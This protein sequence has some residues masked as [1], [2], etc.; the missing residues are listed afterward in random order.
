MK[1]LLTLSQEE[2]RNISERTKWGN[3][4]SAKANKIRNNSLYGYEFD[5]ENNSLIAIK[6]EAD[7]VRLMFNLC[8]EGNGYRLIS[9]RLTSMNLFNRKGLAFPIATIKKYVT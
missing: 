8:I 3:K 5:R 9:E 6:E 7:I 4:A 1:L 2:S